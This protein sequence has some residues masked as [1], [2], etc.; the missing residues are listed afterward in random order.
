MSSSESR[1]G[2][3]FSARRLGGKR[4]FSDGDDDDDDADGLR[5]GDEGE[6]VNEKGVGA[7]GGG[8]RMNVKSSDRAS[9]FACGFSRRGSGALYGGLSG[10]LVAYDR[11]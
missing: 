9:Y 4:V 6:V 3:G 10:N 2:W 1:S 11:D 7:V 8:R 5:K